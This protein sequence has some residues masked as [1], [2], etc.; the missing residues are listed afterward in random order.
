MKRIFLFLFIGLLFIS[1]QVEAR[2][3]IHTVYLGASDSGN[4][5]EASGTSILRVAGDGIARSKGMTII[6]GLDMVNQKIAFQI[7]GA[8]A[9]QA[10]QGLAGEDDSTTLN[11]FF[12]PTLDESIIAGASKYYINS[13]LVSSASPYLI[14]LTGTLPGIIRSM[15]IGIVSGVTPLDG[16]SGILSITGTA[17]KR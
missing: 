13:S 1:T 16:F 2:T 10:E 5:T 3:K 4:T 9:S 15:R 11:I 12:Q 6:H 7:T 14:D 17:S 8:S